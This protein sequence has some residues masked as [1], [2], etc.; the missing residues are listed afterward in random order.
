MNTTFFKSNTKRLILNDCGI[1]HIIK[2]ASKGRTYSE[3]AQEMGITAQAVAQVLKRNNAGQCRN[4]E[5]LNK[6]K[7]FE[8]VE[9]GY[10]GPTIA[11]LMDYPVGTIYSAMHHMGLS[12]KRS[13]K[14]DDILFAK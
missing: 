2:E 5:P 14:L 11:Q 7:L 1:T 12:I 10:S 9:K 6:E 8:Y 4:R 13:S 3:I